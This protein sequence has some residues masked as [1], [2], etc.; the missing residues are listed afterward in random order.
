M[1][2]KKQRLATLDTFRGIAALAVVLFHLTLHQAEAPVHFSWGV[3]GVD[4]FFIISGFVI[5]MTLNKTTRAVDFVF[6]RFSRLYPVYWVAVTLTASWMLIGKYWGYSD[7]S[8]GDYL[9]NMTMFQHYFGVRDLDESYW[10]LIVEMLFY[11]LM[12]LAFLFNKVKN[13]EWYGLVLVVIQAIVHGWVSVSYPYLYTSIR[14]GFPLIN[15]FQLFWAGILYYKIYTE[16]Y[17]LQRVAGIVLAYILTLFLFEKTGRS[18]LFLS[19]P[20]YIA[21]STLY[22]GSFFLFVSQRLEWINNRITRF[23]GTISYSLYVI[24]HYFMNGVVTLLRDKLGWQFVPAA[25]V[26]LMG[27]LVLAV[28]ITYVVEKPALNYLRLRYRS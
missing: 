5:Y 20:E 4:L 23:L 18:N 2:N 14:E 16:G 8:W 15:H 21:V 7:I 25:F 6:A 1:S 11:G 13:L 27:A 10:T 3:T 26:A 12:L 19:W 17:R 22:F 9:A 24:H 28:G